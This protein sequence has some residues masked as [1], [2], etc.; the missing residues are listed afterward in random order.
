MLIIQNDVFFLS[1]FSFFF[2][3]FLALS[4]L[5][6][7]AKLR[8]WYRDLQ[9][10]FHHTCKASLIVNISH[11]GG[12]FVIIDQSIL[13]HHT[14]SLVQLG[15]TWWYIF[16]EFRRMLYYQ[17]GCFHCPR[18]CLGSSFSPIPLVTT[19]LFTCS[20]ILPFPECHIV[21]SIQYVTFPD[22]L[23]SLDKLHSRFL[24]VLQAQH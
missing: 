18:N 11:Q 2:F 10:V 14:K 3:F 20:I 5:E 16:Y 6:F 4:S 23:L 1:F 17:I 12:T 24:H 21:G 9:Y 8:E 7:I 22:G 19:D 13:I 15:F